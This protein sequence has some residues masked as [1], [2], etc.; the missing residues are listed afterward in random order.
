MYPLG[1]QKRLYI[2]MDIQYNIVEYVVHH[3]SI[4]KINIPKKPQPISVKKHTFRHLIHQDPYLQDIFERLEI[5]DKPCLKCTTKM[6]MVFCNNGGI[7][8]EQAGFGMVGSID[9]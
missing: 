3:R 2:P 6:H 9:G 5:I 4:T 8:D 1:D 7:R